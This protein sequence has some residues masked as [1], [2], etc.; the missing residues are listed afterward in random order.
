[1][2]VIA[3]NSHSVVMPLLLTTIAGLSTL[4]GSLIFLFFKRFKNRHLVFCLGLSAGAMLYVSF[5]ELLRTAIIDI[6]F[7]RANI[8]FILG[9][10]IMLIIDMVLPH[11]YLQEQE[12]LNP[13]YKALYPAG[14]FIAAG[15]ALHNFPEGMAVF[16]SGLTDIHLGIALAVAIAVHNIPEG[17]AISIP[18]Y[19]ATRS[20]SKA[21]LFSFFSGIAEPIGAV[22]IIIWLGDSVNQHTV[23]YLFAL[24]AGVM[25]FICFDELLPQ[26]YNTDYH[27]HAIAGILLG[28]LMMIA[29]LAI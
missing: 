9:I 23:S 1:M 21:F 11:Q 17:I 27:K 6:G 14:V 16:L 24:V 2:S 4:I 26:S 5:I 20:K 8:T 10:L 12:G 25:T 22:L 15:I 7:I 29:S 18:I 13:N 28:M 19:Y 3:I